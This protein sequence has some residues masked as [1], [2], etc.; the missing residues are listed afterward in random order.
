[1]EIVQQKMEKGEREDAAADQ[2]VYEA[3][4]TAIQDTSLFADAEVLVEALKI[5]PQPH[6]LDPRTRDAPERMTEG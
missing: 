1:M 6:G 3:R 2:A 4:Q 5:P